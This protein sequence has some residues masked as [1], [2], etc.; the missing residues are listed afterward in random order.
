[1]GYTSQHPLRLPRVHC[2]SRKV[3]TATAVAVHHRAARRLDWLPDPVRHHAIIAQPA[4]LTRIEHV[5]K[6]VVDLPLANVHLGRAKIATVLHA[7][8]SEESDP[9][10]RADRSHVLGLTRFKS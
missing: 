9:F 6:K 3:T 8:R 10:L 5:R 2:E 7:A 1:M 4:S